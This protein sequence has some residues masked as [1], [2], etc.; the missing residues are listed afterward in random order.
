MWA[1]LQEERLSTAPR[2]VGVW[3]RA[4]VSMSLLSTALQAED[5]LAK[6]YPATAR[7]Q[8]RRVPATPHLGK[9]CSYEELFVSV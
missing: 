4:A 2:T 6:T 7:G 8:T 9:N 3:S 5:S 1:Q